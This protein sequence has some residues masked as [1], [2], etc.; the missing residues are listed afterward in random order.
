MFKKDSMG[1]ILQENVGKMKTFKERKLGYH[2]QREI[3]R[4]ATKNEEENLK[5][6]SIA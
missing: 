4:S 3:G 2:D 5:T 1:S 6:I